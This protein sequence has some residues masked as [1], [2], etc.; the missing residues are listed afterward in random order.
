M[1][2]L[3]TIGLR[4]RMD[5]HLL[6]ELAHMFYKILAS[7]IHGEH[8]LMEMPGELCLFYSLSEG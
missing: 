4:L 3:Y 6:L 2:I 5:N 7:I 1:E 8:G